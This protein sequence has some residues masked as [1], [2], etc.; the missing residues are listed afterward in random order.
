M[1]AALSFIAM[2]LMLGW[3]NRIAH[4]DYGVILKIQ[5]YGLFGAVTDWYMLWSGRWAA[6][7]TLG[8]LLQFFYAFGCLWLY[9]AITLIFLFVALYIFLKN[10]SQLVTQKRLKP[11]QLVTYAGLFST[12]FFYLS[13]DIG[14]TWFWVTG[15][16]TY[17]W[18]IIAFI[19]GIGLVLSPKSNFIT[20]LG[21]VVSFFF[22][23]ASNEGFAMV[24]LIA[25]GGAIILSR[26]RGSLSKAANTKLIGAFVILLGGF[27][28]L[29]VAPGNGVRREYFPD[30]NLFGTLKVSLVSYKILLK[31]FIL[32]QAPY[33]LLFCLPWIAIGAN[34]SHKK[35]PSKKP[36][37]ALVI[38]AIAIAALCFLAVV[39]TAYALV[40]LGPKRYLS[41][42]S[43]YLAIGVMTFGFYIGYYFKIPDSIPKLL[44]II[45]ATT[46]LGLNIY[47]LIVQYPI[48]HDYAKAED[49]RI[50]LLHKEQNR[51][52]KEMLLLD[53]LP[54]SGLL[55]SNELSNDTNHF[56]NKVM[57][58]ALGLGYTIRVKTWA[59]VERSQ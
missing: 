3:F 22:C 43:F 52:R 31:E 2:V 34:Y 41:Q 5:N 36:Y 30:V 47:N 35:V 8:A 23:G 59:E 1:L 7:L 16:V 54:P 53:P 49:Q 6:S 27:I 32:P 17:L 15:S 40:S 10:L 20:W 50:E 55:K 4:D 58:D 11:F 45:G 25:L 14:E 24:M 33:L 18:S 29:A 26:L 21:I 51:N 57:K 44:G 12:S 28:T 39:P 37:L 46:I 13:Y 56:T 42:V 38:I 19:L 9:S 48:A